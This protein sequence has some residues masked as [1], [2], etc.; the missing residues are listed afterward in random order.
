MDTEREEEDDEDFSEF[1]LITV[2]ITITIRC[3]DDNDLRM[4]ERKNKKEN[5]LLRCFKTS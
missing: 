1:D 2:E 3:L 5:Y 4:T